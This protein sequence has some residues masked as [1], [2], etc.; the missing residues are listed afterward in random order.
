MREFVVNLEIRKF[1][2]KR[3]REIKREREQRISSCEYFFVRI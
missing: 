3:E 2:K 1:I